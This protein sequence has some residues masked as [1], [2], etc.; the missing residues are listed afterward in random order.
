LPFPAKKEERDEP[1][2]LEPVHYIG[3]RTKVPSVQAIANAS[4]T[5]SRLW[6]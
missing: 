2:P 4:R 6:N 5:D 1:G 3:D